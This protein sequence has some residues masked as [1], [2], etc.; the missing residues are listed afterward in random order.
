MGKEL[1]RF[2]INRMVRNVLQKNNVDMPQIQ[3]SCMGKHVHITGTLMKAGNKDFTPKNIENL[4]RELSGIP[5]VR[6]IM[7]NLENW[8]IA[9]GA[10]SAKDSN[11]K[12]KNA[13]SG[14]VM[15]SGKKEEGI[16]GQNI[17]KDRVRKAFQ[18]E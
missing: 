7:F 5:C 9:G 14:S 17:D 3:Y 10:I 13:G 4:T 6:E 18:D 15:A 12:K 1:S 2:E 16:A 11:E 8:N